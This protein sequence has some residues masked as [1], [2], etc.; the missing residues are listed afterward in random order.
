MAFTTAAKLAD[1]P[2]G[3][4]KQVIIQG[5]KIALFQ[6]GGTVRAIDDTC[7]HRG[8]S[9]S[10]GQCRQGQVMCPWHAT[11]FDLT[12]G[13]PLCPPAKS[14]VAVYPVQIVGDEIQIDI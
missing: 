2:A 4:G 13:Q 10:E 8:A 6:D 3:R 11:R 1:V 5:R 9:L 7:P 12:S 14:G